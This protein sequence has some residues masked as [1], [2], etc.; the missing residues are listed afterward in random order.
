MRKLL[1]LVALLAFAPSARGAPRRPLGVVIAGAKGRVPAHEP[2]A[3][4]AK[5]S[6]HGP[7][8][9]FTY[10]WRAIDGALPYDSASDSSKLAIP[11]DALTPGTRYD[12]ELTVVASF[13]EPDSEPPEQTA[14]AKGR[15]SFVVNAPPAGGGCEMDVRWIGTSQAALELSAPGWTDDHSRVQYRFVVVRNGKATIAKNWSQFHKHSTTAL[16]RPGDE[17]QAKCIV[18]DEMGDGAEAAS[19]KFVRPAP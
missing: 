4:T 5:V 18:R 2:V 17:L 7:K 19:V 16:A 10:E 8:A 13:V 11:V 6:W 9:T 3:L 12:L 15:V 14:E 1:L